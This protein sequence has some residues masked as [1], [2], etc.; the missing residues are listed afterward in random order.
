MNSLPKITLLTRHF[1]SRGGLEKWAGLIAQGF[2]KKG[3]CVDILTADFIEKKDLHPLI[4]VQTLPL[5]GWGK[6][7]AFDRLCQKWAKSPIVFG[8]DRTTHQTHL[9]AGNGVHKTYLER[10][11]TF[12]NYS[13]LKEALNPLNKTI[14][15]IEKKAFESPFLKVLFTNSYMVKNEILHHYNV[16]PE[17]IEV[18][19]NG[20]HWKEMEKPFNGWIGEKKALCNTLKLDVEK[21]HFLFVG[22]GYE[23]KGLSFLLKALSLLPNRDFHLSVVGKDPEL[24][25]F[26]LLANQLGLSKHVTFFGPMADMIPFYQLADSLVIPSTYDP[27][28][29]VTVEALSMGLFTISSKYNGGYEILK[30]ESGAVIEALQ[31]PDSLKEVL[32][33]AIMHPKTW[34]RSQTIRNSVKHLDLSSQVSSLIDLT[35][36]SL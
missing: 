16:S 30:E 18:I 9:R 35:L 28:A 19:H 17:K 36:E 23:R 7:K 12:E 34:V 32:M 29:N 13:P 3:A 33:R 22:N 10:R 6:M 14:L 25:R 2:A 15:Q 26:M 8:M 11:K 27:F 21:Y 20:A 4:N 24:E 31:D 5:K 1:K